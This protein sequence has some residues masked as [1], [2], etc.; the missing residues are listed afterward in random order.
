MFVQIVVFWAVVL[1]PTDT[2]KY[3]L[4]GLYI[5][6]LDRTCTKVNYVYYFPSVY[7]LKLNVSLK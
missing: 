4:C 5:R 3:E 6:T 2:V 1:F 7:F